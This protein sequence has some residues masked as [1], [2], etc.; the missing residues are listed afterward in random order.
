MWG[1][2]TETQLRSW[3]CKFHQLLLGKPNAD[4]YIDDRCIQDHSFFN[5]NETV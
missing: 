3:G 4:Y 5:L 2:M 1:E